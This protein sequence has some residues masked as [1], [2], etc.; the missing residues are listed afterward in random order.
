MPFFSENA[1]PES[2]AKQMSI[3]EMCHKIKD[4]IL[5]TPH[6]QREYVWPKKLQQGYL[7]T[8]AKNGPIHGAI[9]NHDPETG[10]YWIMDGQNRLKTIYYFVIGK[11]SYEPN[12][13]N[14]DMPCER[15]KYSDLDPIEKRKFDNQNISYIETRNWS[16]STSQEHFR[17]IQESVKLKEGEKIH[18]SSENLFTKKIVEICSEFGY[19]PEED[20]NPK[21]PVGFFDKK[22]KDGGLG[23]P[24]KRYKH[25][26]LIGCL[27]NMV[28]TGNYPDRPGKTA[29]QC[30]KDWDN[31]GDVENLNMD[32]NIV[33]KCLKTY[34]KVVE[35]VSR[36]R[37]SGFS[38]DPTFLRNMYFIFEK[39]M[40]SMEWSQEEY[41][42]FESVMNIVLNKEHPV[43]KEIISWGTNGGGEKIFNKYVELYNV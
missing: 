16:D 2:N 9:I 12:Y 26:E 6:F 10:L 17:E 14:D 23:I 15:I 19:N 18:S 13:D 33:I 34:E 20:Y 38:K 39:K 3:S 28:N 31:G 41:N 1:F 27:L 5:K 4:G 36:L 42:R 35:N 40:Y 30:L 37:G 29:L 24:F 8:L 22:I 21:D 7:N 25:Y 11:L 43:A 32:G